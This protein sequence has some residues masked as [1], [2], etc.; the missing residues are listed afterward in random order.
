MGG[1][2]GVAALLGGGGRGQDSVTSGR[3]KHAASKTSIGG[4]AGAGAIAVW[5]DAWEVSGAANAI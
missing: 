3:P 1:A 5:I 2:L 4:P